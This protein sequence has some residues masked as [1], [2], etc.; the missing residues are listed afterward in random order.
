MYY[1]NFVFANIH[2][3]AE[4]HDATT[5]VTTEGDP[6]K[7]LATD[8]QALLY[9]MGFGLINFFFAAPAFFTIDTIGRRTLLLCTFPFLAISH[10]ITT[11]AFAAKST[12]TGPYVALVGMYL[13][14]IFYSFGE[15]PVPFVYA[16]ES[17]PLYCRE[18]A[19]ALVVSINWLFNWLI[20]FSG[21]WM[22]GAMRPASTF[23]FYGLWCIIIWFMILFLVPE[24]RLLKL[25]E[26]DFVFDKVKT[27]QF[28][29]HALQSLRWQLHMDEKPKR[30]YAGPETIVRAEREQ[31]NRTRQ[32]RHFGTVANHA[33]V[34]ERE[35]V[36]VVSEHLRSRHLRRISV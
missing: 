35:R 31:A 18:Q 1:S 8:Q 28:G 27:R 16:S 9:T 4:L 24:T 21:P 29:S 26:I 30:L 15:G 5:G 36:D 3:P 20:A 2:L 32:G 19:M 23:A 13:F 7:R 34:A 11:A 10:F 12:T 17:M 6:A 22:F 25:E 14:G 33:V